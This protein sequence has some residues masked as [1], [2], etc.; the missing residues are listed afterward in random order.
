MSDSICPH[1]DYDLAGLPD[2]SDRCPECGNELSAA[3]F[4]R[5]AARRVARHSGARLALLVSP[6]IGI[7]A[8]LPSLVMRRGAVGYRPALLLLVLC[9]WSGAGFALYVTARQKDDRRRFRRAV[10]LGLPLGLGYFLALILAALI[11]VLVIVSLD[12]LLHRVR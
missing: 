5:A 3:A 8:G 11:A 9:F 6:V 10:L 2:G 1:C 7:F 12:A 4:A